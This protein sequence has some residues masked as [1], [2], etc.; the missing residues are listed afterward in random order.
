MAYL[1]SNKTSVA[2][3]RCAENGWGWRE[4]ECHGK[5]SE[6]SSECTAELLEVDA[7][8]ASKMIILCAM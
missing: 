5:E 2:G 8:L 1:T 6:L 3:T 7:I 4:V